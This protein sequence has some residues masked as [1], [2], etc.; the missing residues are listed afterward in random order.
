MKMKKFNT[1]MLFGVFLILYIL[2]L[3]Y[4]LLFKNVSPLEIFDLKRQYI[5]NFNIIPF[6]TIKSYLSFSNR[7]IA[8]DNIIGNIILFIPLGIY[9]QLFEKSRKVFVSIPV[10]FLV[11]L[12]VEILQFA[13]ALGAA[14]VDDIILNLLGGV[15]G[16]LIYRMLCRLLKSEERVRTAIVIAGTIIIVPLLVLYGMMWIYSR[17]V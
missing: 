4:A 14:D 3:C 15:F 12:S 8:I 6:H 16:I 2:L 10:I 5:R 13:L 7:F 1:V 17:S 9:L 11:T